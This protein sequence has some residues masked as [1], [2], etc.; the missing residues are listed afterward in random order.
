L[1]LVWHAPSLEASDA[2]KEWYDEVQIHGFSKLNIPL[3]KYV[4][5]AATGKSAVVAGR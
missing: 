2:S 3:V 4:P 5:D 1:L